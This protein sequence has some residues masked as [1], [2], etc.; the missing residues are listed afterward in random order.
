MDKVKNKRIALVALLLVLALVASVFAFTTPLRAKADGETEIDW[1]SQF[2]AACWNADNEVRLPTTQFVNGDGPSD[3]KVSSVSIKRG[4]TA[5]AASHVYIWGAN[6][7]FYFIGAGYDG[8]NAQNGDTLIITNDFTVS[9]NGVNYISSEEIS[10][11][12]SDGIWAIPVPEEDLSG[13]TDMNIVKMATSGRAGETPFYVYTDSAH[14]GNIEGAN[15]LQY[16]IMRYPDGNIADVWYCRVDSEQARFFVHSPDGSGGNINLPGEIPQGSTFT[17]KRG[18]RLD[19]VSALKEDKVFIFA[20]DDFAPYVKTESFEVEDVELLSGGKTALS[21]T[22]TPAN[23]ND[24]V[25][26]TV[27]AG[28]D[29]I[30]VSGNELTAKKTG[31]AT[32]T[33]KIGDLETKTINV[34]VLDSSD[35]DDIEITGELAIWQYENINDL[36]ISTLSG[37]FVIGENKYDM[38]V[39]AD[40]ISYPDGFTTATAG[41]YDATVTFEA[42]TTITKTVK[43]TVKSVSALSIASIGLDGAMHSI[44]VNW[45]GCSNTLQNVMSGD[46]HTEFANRILPYVEMKFKNASGAITPAL[47]MVNQNYIWIYPSVGG[48]V[49]D[50]PDYAAGDTVKFKEGLRIGAGERLASDITY[51]Y[52]GTTFVVLVEPTAVSITEKPE[53]LFL[54]ATYRLKLASTPSDATE[55]VYTY[56]SSNPEYAT[57]N[58]GVITAKQV[59]DETVQSVTVTV[60]YKDISDS[61]TFT[62]V[63]ELPKKGIELVG[64]LPQYYIPVSTT[65]KPTSLYGQGFKL[66]YRYI[67]DD[68]SVSDEFEVTEDMLGEFDYTTAGDRDLTVTVTSGENTYTQSVGIHVYEYAVI[69]RWKAIGVDGYGDDRNEGGK[70]FNGNMLITANNYSASRANVKGGKELE[71]MLGYMEYTTA[72]GSTKYTLSNGKLGMWLL[73]STVMI[74]VNGKG[75]TGAP[76]N[77]YMLGDKILFKQGMPLYGWSGEIIP[78]D[79]DDPENPS[80]IKPGTGCMYVIGYLDADYTYFCYEQDNKMSLWDLYKEYTDFT[81]G[82]S[83]IV[84]TVGGTGSIGAQCTPVDATTGK[85]GYVSSDENIVS[86]NEYGNLLGKATGKATVTVTLTGGKDEEGNAVAP[87]V[88]TV[89]VEVKRGIAKIEGDFIIKAGSAFNPSEHKIKVT[90]TDGTVEEIALDDDRVIADDVDAANLDNP[91]T[92]MVT[93]DGNSRKGTFT[94]TIASKGGCNCGS[95]IG[96]IGSIILG[97]CAIAI[98]MIAVR[99]RNRKEN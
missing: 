22:V 44:S 31:T 38:S 6:L 34:T 53:Q 11:V 83:E 4:T 41:E 55:A 48:A 74:S 70:Q 46:A 78:Q 97:L 12:Y 94:V 27:T 5:F 91:Y 36:D 15:V 66:S 87:I 63:A 24:I 81:V 29:V 93:I 73:G 62:I 98:A 26:Y 40:M 54:N 64:A 45:N 13:Y 43:L 99:R 90:F 17:I 30:S 56:T 92:V 23:S 25:T 2:T 3:G 20:G 19:E 7:T 37:K 84:L 68:D 9:N 88:K 76:E 58:N 89:N 18:F 52:N 16:V 69:G 35:A 75:F 21:V 80:K 32:V 86:V 8:K 60:S 1:P 61:I 95:S 67:Y 82:S 42:K 79:P 47:Q 14:T 50:H 51:V 65:E 10:Y 72:D 28:S 59:T 77:G 96:G 57:V 49:I 85:F 71:E 39:T 33:V